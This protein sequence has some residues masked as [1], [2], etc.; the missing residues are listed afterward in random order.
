MA[1]NP[2]Q[3]VQPGDLITSAW[4]NGIV[5][6]INNLA[7][8][9]AAL[10]SPPDDHPSTSG[11]PVLTGRTPSG[12]VHVTD[13][14]T[15]LGQNFSP[16]SS[17]R[18]NFGGLTVSSFLAGSSDTQLKFSVPNVPPGPIGIT[19]STPEGT[20]SNM[21]PVNVLP[22]VAP[23]GGHVSVAPA[24]D[25]SNPPNPQANQPLQLQWTVASDTIDPD[26]YTLAVEFSNIQPSGTAWSASLNATQATI[27]PGTPYTAVATVQVPASGKADVTLRATSKTDPSR[28]SASLPVTLAVGVATETSDPRISFQVVDPQPDYDS[29][30]NPSKAALIY[31][32]GLPVIL[33]SANS[34]A[35]VQVRVSFSDTSATPPVSYRF[36]ADV[37]DTTNWAAHAPS[38]PTLVQSSLGGTTLVLYNLTNEAT[39]TAPHDAHITV[40]AAKV[41][42][43]TDDYVSFAPIALRNAG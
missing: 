20:S 13:Q 3:H 11:R 2:L 42:G 33:V 41:T 28:T 14:L 36:F 35:A 7:A 4:A 9:L 26:T 32:N 18:V 17:A 25:P 19:V 31:E 24:N 40:R 43:A 1:I 16:L 39:D 27:A 15:L 21:L 23:Q 10:G 6:E 5:D 29:L 12:D 22:A 38:P 37:D 30:G 34:D 8:Q